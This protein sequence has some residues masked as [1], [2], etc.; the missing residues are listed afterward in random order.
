MG[1]NRYG[2]STDVS[3]SP[4]SSGTVTLD[5]RGIALAGAGVGAEDLLVGEDVVREDQRPGVDQAADELEVALVLVL[6]RVDEDDVEDVL[7]GR[8]RLERVALDQLRPLLEPGLGN[9]GAPVGGDLRIA[10]QR[11]DA[12]AQEPRGGGEPDRRVRAAGA[13][14]EHL[15]VGLRGDDREEKTAGRRLDRHGRCARLL[16][17]QAC[18]HAAHALVHHERGSSRTAMR[19]A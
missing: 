11:D 12:P 4:L 6:L 16:S 3:S 17:R 13:D 2:L 7:E 14:L 15:A 5:E 19:A 1:R 8:E 10:L 9:V 18:E